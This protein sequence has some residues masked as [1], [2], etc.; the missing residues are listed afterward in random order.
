V[1][2]SAG[3]VHHLGVSETRQ[4]AAGIPFPEGRVRLT[5]ARSGGPGGQNVNKVETKVVARLPLWA[6]AALLTPDALARV[7]R[8]LANRINDADELMVTSSA[9]RY[10]GRNVEDA[11]DRMCEMI[12]RAMQRPPRR[13]PT[14]P[15]RGSRERRLKAK[16][17]RGEVKRQ[18]RP[19]SE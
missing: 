8:R 12:R 10:R 17:E 18:R 2:L 19:P 11:L 3:I 7:R 1:A 14:R 5:Y 6:L 16:R 15:T 4:L 13:R 9:T